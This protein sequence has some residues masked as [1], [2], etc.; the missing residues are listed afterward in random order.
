MQTARP[1]KL[2]HLIYLL[3][4]I[5]AACSG[6]DDEAPSNGEG[7]L[8][9]VPADTPYVFAATKPLPDD[10][11]EKFA[12]HVEAIVESYSSLMQASLKQEP[13]DDEET[14]LDDGSRK[15]VAAMIDQLAGMVTAEGIPEAG[16]D[17]DSTMAIYGVGLLPVLRV[18]LSDGDRFEATMAKLESDAGEKMSVA[19][20]DGHSYRY[21]GDDEG[22]LIIAEIDQQMVVSLVP[23]G[24]PEAQLKSVLGIDLPAESI[25]E[26]GALAELA[27]EYG[28]QSYGLGMIDVLRVAATFLDD[29]TGVNRELLTMMDY[30]ASSLSDVCKTEIRAL[31]GIA[32]RVVAGYTDITEDHIRSM[33]AVE[34]RSDIATGLQTLTAPVPGLGAEQGGL[35]SFGLSLNLLAARDFYSARLDAIEADPYECEL[36]AD[37]QD[38]VARGREIL[39]QPI[40]PI[41][42][43]F[44]GFLAVIDDI[45]GMDLAKQQP[46]TAVDMRVLL[47]TDNADGLLAMGAMFSPEIASLDLKPDSKPVKLTLPAIASSMAE[48]AYVAMSESALAL[49]F[50]TGSEPGLEAMLGADPNDPSPFISTDMDAARYYGFIGDAMTLSDNDDQSAEVIQAQSEVMKTFQKMFS[51]ISFDVLFTER[52][53]EMPST[54]ELAD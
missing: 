35:M 33:S 29:Q 14:H 28:F 6:G 24:L 46:P 49:S 44:R 37:L 36:F 4:L 26:T 3:P 48:A 42:Y 47:A 1:A 18:T 39:N 2:R 41:V 53:V 38:G 45:K 32:P 31:A 21:A 10:V 43:G 12:P 8:S 51:R 16:I 13:G 52:G 9:Y 40:P 23:A 11:R 34:L 17:R 50:G 19:S 7:I 30:D 54:M 22:R 15:R 5:L 27:E 25:A 20:I